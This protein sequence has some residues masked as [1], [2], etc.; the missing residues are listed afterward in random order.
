MPMKVLNWNFS[1]KKLE[2]KSFL[3]NA[4]RMFIRNREDTCRIRKIHQLRAAYSKLRLR[5]IRP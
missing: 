5:T 4:K 2:L 3:E 1:S